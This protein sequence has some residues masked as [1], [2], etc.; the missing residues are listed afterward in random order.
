M[1]VLRL[2]GMAATTIIHE[3]ESASAHAND[4]R[5]AAAIATRA[6]L[7]ADVGFAVPADKARK[8]GKVVDA[9]FKETK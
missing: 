6:G 1:V 9:E 3:A 5:S 7:S 2:Q 8:D 4:S